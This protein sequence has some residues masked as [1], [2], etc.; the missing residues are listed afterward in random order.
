M[1]YLDWLRIFLAALLLRQ[2]RIFV[3]FHEIFGIK[4]RNSRLHF[5]CDLY[6][7]P[8]CIRIR[9]KKFRFTFLSSCDDLHI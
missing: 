2:L 1:F 6:E 7:Y 4:K 8:V 5:S 3:N 9:I